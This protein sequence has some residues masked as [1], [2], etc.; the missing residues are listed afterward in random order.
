MTAAI[1]VLLVTADVGPAVD[2]I[3][4][5]VSDLDR[6]V[7]FYTQ[8]LSFE[9]VSEVEL[10]GQEI[11]H[12]TGVFGSHIRRARLKLGSEFIELTEFLAPQ[13]RLAPTDQRSND[14]WFQHI[15]IITS[16]MDRAY[17]HLANTR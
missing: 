6:S 7:A 15:A 10:E 8:V 9:K 16:D 2:S 12:L 11:E 3:G 13:G 1:L 17:R 14:R 4:M 5:T